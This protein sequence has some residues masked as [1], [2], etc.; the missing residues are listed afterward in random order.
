VIAVTFS[1]ALIFTLALAT[2]ALAQ[3]QGDTHVMGAAL[4]AKLF[5][6]Y[7]ACDLTA[8]GQLLS[9]DVE[10]YHDKGGLMLGR[11]TVV[12]A[13]EKNVCGKV[14]RELLPGTLKSYP[15]DNYG[16]VQFGEHRFCTAG[17]TTCTGVARFAHLWKQHDGRWLATRIIS[18]DHQPL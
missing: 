1:V 9:P 6:A 15:M 13:V 14:R 18:Y 11:Q 3:Q 12:D 2:P 8:F 4:D 17:T 7:N 16:I 5:S 10:F